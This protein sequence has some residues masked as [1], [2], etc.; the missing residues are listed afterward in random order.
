MKIKM[1]KMGMDI[2][3]TRNETLSIEEQSKKLAY[4]KA[5]TVFDK[6]SGKDRLAVPRPHRHRP[7]LR[8]LH[9]ALRF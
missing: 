5:K 3:E 4:I 8:E 7:P 1:V 9:D 2:D 6:T